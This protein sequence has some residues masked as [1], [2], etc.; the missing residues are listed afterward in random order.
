MKKQDALSVLLIPQAVLQGV[1]KNAERAEYKME[2][3]TL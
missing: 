2:S 1:Q 3:L